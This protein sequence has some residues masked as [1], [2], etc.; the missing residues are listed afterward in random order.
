MTGIISITTPDGDPVPATDNVG[1][2][3]YY[4][5][6]GYVIETVE[7]EP[8]ADGGGEPQGDP[9]PFDPAEHSV[10][11]VTAYLDGLDDTDTEAHA[12]EVTRVL[13]AERNGKNRSTLVGAPP[14]E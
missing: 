7:A 10:A 3:A 9:V 11:E 13:E 14:V 4:R 8:E 5:R 12:A 2:L 6:K 1:R